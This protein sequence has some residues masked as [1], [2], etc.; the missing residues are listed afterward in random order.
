MKK[1]HKQIKK[2]S[3]TICLPTHHLI[4]LRILLN[5]SAEMCGGLCN[6]LASCTAF[7]VAP[8]RLLSIVGPMIRSIADNIP[9]IDVYVS[10]SVSFEPGISRADIFEGYLCMQTAKK[11]IQEGLN[12]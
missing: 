12:K 6:L 10:A 1:K 5:R 11:Y 3:N 8:C 2:Q 7:A 4:T 9:A